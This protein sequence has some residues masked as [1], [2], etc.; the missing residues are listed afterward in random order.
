M[1]RIDFD[2]NSKNVLLDTREGS[3][4]TDV[5]VWDQRTKKVTVFIEATRT[6]CETEYGQPDWS[7][8]CH[9]VQTI[10]QDRLIVH[11]ANVP[12]DESIPTVAELLSITAK[13]IVGKDGEVSRN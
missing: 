10:R 1:P 2:I 8:A 4:I 9:G 7:Q 5:L 12:G 3:Q 6:T 13:V 11:A